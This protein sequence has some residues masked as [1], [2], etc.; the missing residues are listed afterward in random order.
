ML[1]RQS[2]NLQDNKFMFDEQTHTYRLNDVVIPSVTQIIRSVTGEDLSHIPQRNLKAAAERGTA[3]HREI[4]TGN[5][6]SAE[7]KWIEKNINRSACLFEAMFYHNHNGFMFAGTADIVGT[8][9]LFDIKSQ[10]KENIPLWT[11]QLNLYNLFF[12]S[13][14]LKVLHVPNTGIFKVY[15]IPFLSEEAIQEVFDCYQSKKNLKEFNTMAKQ[16][17]EIVAQPIALSLEVYTQNVGELTTNA[18]E[19]KERVKNQIELYKAENYTPENIDAAK[20]DKAELNKSAKLLNDKRIEIERAFMAPIEEFK[21]TVNETVSLIKTASNAIDE[22]VKEV[23]AQDKAVKKATIIE[24]FNSLNFDLVDFALLFNEKWLNKTMKLD[25]VFA[26][27]NSK[28]EKIKNDLKIL[29]RLGEEEA[30]E[31]Y[32]ST[33][34]LDAAFAKA[35]EI[36][37]NRERLAKVENQKTVIEQIE[38]IPAIEAAPFMAEQGQTEIVDVT[39]LLQEPQAAQTA[40]AQLYTVQFSVSGSETQLLA[41]QSFMDEQGLEYQFLK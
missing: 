30:K 31:F 28:T 7:A 18:K 26:E 8:D 41:L 3:I 12:K 39:G 20:K 2:C 4:E 13:K 16:T 27:L 5:I 40:T 25:D 32:L 17:K 21:T 37:A 36:K 11:L 23:E 9:I 29:D 1:N 35:D 24:Y 22:I 19:L 14:K 33:L 6:Q 10:A 38:D 34:D 15:D